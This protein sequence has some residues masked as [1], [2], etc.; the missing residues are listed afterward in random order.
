VATAETK[1]KSTF[2]I[3]ISQDRMSATITL[4]ERVRKNSLTREDVVAAIEE[5]S[6]SVDDQ[7]EP[8]IK[9][10][11]DQVNKTGKCES[12]HL[13]A[14][15]VP[16]QNAQDETLIW[17]PTFQAQADE[18]QDDAA[19]NYYPTRTVVTVQ[20]GDLIGHISPAKDAKAGTDVTGE[21]VAGHGIPS[22]LTLDSTLQRN[23]ETNEVTA[24]ASGVVVVQ[25]DT[26]TIQPRSCVTGS[27][28]I[29]TGDIKISGHLFIEDRIND[30]MACT[31]K[32]SITV[33][34]AIEAARVYAGGGLYV[35]KGIIGRRTGL[36]Q[37]D[38]AIIAKYMTD[39]NTVCQRDLIVS[40]QLM[41]S[42]TCVGG[43]VFATT[44]SI[45]GGA[46]YARLGIHV[47]TLGSSA[48]VPTKIVV[49]VNAR[50]VRRIAEIDR[51][52]LKIQDVIK[53]IRFAID[54][55]S[56]KGDQSTD[57]QTS[58]ARE[59]ETKIQA[60][61]GLL[62]QDQIRREECV[63][64]IQS[65]EPSFVEISDII[66]PKVTIQIGDRATSINEE[67]KGPVRIEKQKVRNVTEMVAIS[68]KTDRT[69]VLTSERCKPEDFLEG[70]RLEQEASAT[71][72]E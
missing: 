6:I 33:G 49:G 45:I 22:T 39:A 7:I 21:E 9:S 53:R 10:F 38:G 60:S 13:I 47:A 57:Q 46:T 27:V 32:G 55:V 69:T 23:A 5:A 1:V 50:D 68:L 51:R 62:L 11:L 31:A 36:V 4:R 35:R 29:E 42:Y 3:A 34:G 24:N 30:G 61:E 15:G 19:V 41:N 40:A 71:N 54:S 2:V 28:C 56:A 37:S 16:A 25:D 8:R 64:N 65:D 20:K 14:E 12:P 67:I 44:A 43:L 17:T 72:P 66:F 59:L 18:W 26:L 48:N 70:C 58:L 52:S 63:A